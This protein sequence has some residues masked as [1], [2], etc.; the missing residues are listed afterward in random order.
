MRLLPPE[1]SY[2]GRRYID[3]YLLP[4][5]RSVIVVRQHPAKVV[6]ALA[7]AIGGLLVAFAVGSVSENA[8]STHLLVW[9]LAAF[10]VI[11]AFLEIAN[12]LV[13]NIVLT[14]QRLILT[15][16]LFSRKVM[17]FPLVKLLDMTF[18]RSTAGSLFGYG[19]FSIESGGGRAKAAIDYIPYPE[20]LYLELT[21]LLYPGS[22]IWPEDEGAHEGPPDPGDSPAASGSAAR[23]DIPPETGPG[24]GGRPGESPGTAPDSG[25]GG[26]EEAAETASDHGAAEPPG[27]AAETASDHDAAEPPGEAA[28]TAS[29][30]GAGEP[31]EEAP[32]TAPDSGA[33]GREEGSGAALGGGAGPSGEAPGGGALW[34]GEAAGTVP[35]SGA[36][37]PEEGSEAPPDDGAGR[38]GEDP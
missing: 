20:Q 11:R 26:L 6:P 32:G 21:N 36:G 29:D 10:L 27:E 24:G 35:D 1:E 30:H 8:R 34:L 17:A 2:Q 12:W 28:E 19:T 25:A 14:D 5:E 22:A 15:S 33:G 18:S 3:K 7:E 4:S 13:Q 38:P 31:P 23:L 37:G 16:G 9:I